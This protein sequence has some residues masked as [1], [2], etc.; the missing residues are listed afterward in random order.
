MY[1]F[2]LLGELMVITYKYVN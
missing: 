1:W 2:E